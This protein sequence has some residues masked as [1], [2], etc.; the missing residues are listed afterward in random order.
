M[1]APGIPLERITFDPKLNRN[2]KKAYAHSNYQ[3]S[4]KVWL[5]FKTPFWN[6]TQ[7]AEEFMALFTDLSIKNIVYQPL[8]NTGTV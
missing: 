4:A 2:K 6:K 7:N 1:T 8:K 5:A 3:D